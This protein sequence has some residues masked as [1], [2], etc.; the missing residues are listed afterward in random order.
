MKTFKTGRPIWVYYLDIDSGSNLQVPQ[1]VRGYEGDDY[2][3]VKREF[4]QYKLVK[5]TGETV[6]NFDGNQQDVHFYYRKKSWGEIED[7][8][9]YL[10]LAKPT[11]QFDQV[12]GMPIDKPL[13]GNMYVRSF[14]RVATTTGEFWY[15]INA[16]RWIKFD[17]NSMKITHDD[18]FAK[19]PPVKDGPAADLRVLPLNKIKA[20]VDYL[21]GGHLYTYDY[22]YGEST[23]TVANGQDLVLVGRLEDENGVT[24]Y[25]DESRGFINGAYV[26]LNEVD[27]D[28]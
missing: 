8:D 14:K 5:T 17:V 23:G 7:I 27:E 12:A 24:W 25:Q 20:T 19:E 22:P 15:E 6:G 13:P 9:L 11:Q 16:D 21:K 26:H 18:P 4:P 1:L 2:T 28:E 3:I 10:S